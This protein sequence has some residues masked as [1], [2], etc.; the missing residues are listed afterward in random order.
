MTYQISK[1]EEKKLKEA[2]KKISEIISELHNKELEVI[3]LICAVKDKE[4]YTSAVSFGLLS[5][6]DVISLLE[7]EK[8]RFYELL[9][10]GV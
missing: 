10:E 1:E 2:L 7:I 8:L 4:G 9:K 5:P 3:E 6:N